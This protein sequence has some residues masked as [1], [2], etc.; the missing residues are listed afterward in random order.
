MSTFTI[1]LV[2][3]DRPI[4]MLRMREQ[5]DTPLHH[6]NN[7]EL[8][9]VTAGTGEHLTADGAW[10]IARGDVLVIPVGMEHGYARC[11]SLA[12]VNLG[13]DLA[14][15]FI[16]EARLARLPGYHALTHLEPRLRAH[17]EFASHL[18]LDERQLTEVLGSIERL[19]AEQQERVP[20]HDLA[21]TAL[22]TQ[23]L[24]T[25]AR[26]YAGAETPAAR[27]LVRLAELLAWIDLN[28][29]RPIRVEQLATKVERAVRKHERRG[30]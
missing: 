25:C 1:D 10:D 6:H 11:R 9:V 2:S 7:V 12:L 3:A 4:G 16:P 13:Y 22:L 5:G 28:H 19:E 29:A 20:G 26:C 23:I 24:V 14:G 15:A 18:R 17:H 8:A 27:A 30:R 21:G